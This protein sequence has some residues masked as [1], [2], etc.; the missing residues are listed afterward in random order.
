MISSLPVLSGLREI[1]QTYDAFLLD[2]WGVV[3]DGARI[4]DGAAECLER[5]HTA[6]KS[7]VFVS[8]SPRRATNIEEFFTR[9]GIRREWYKAIVTSGE[10]AHTLLRDKAWPELGR[11]FYNLW[12][13][14]AVPEGMPL[15]SP[16]CDGALDFTR[17]SDVHSADFLFGGLAFGESRSLVDFED[18][19]ALALS[20]SLPFLCVNPDRVVGVGADIFM[21][22]GRVAERYEEMG[23]RVIWIGKPYPEVY[24]A[25]FRFLEGADKSR[26]AAIGDS[27]VTDIAGAEGAGIAGIFN[28]TGIHWEELRMDHRPDAHDL[29]KVE[30]LLAAH[31]HRPTAALCG[32]RW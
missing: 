27:L 25:A 21:M 8:N 15:H 19:L 23:G 12:E 14:C 22:P 1:A 16:L 30:T 4:Y 5:L 26:V 13:G 9:C 31:P 18:V 3:W 32:L 7:L 2:I 24:D 29:E 28:M 10:T 11:K 20:R 6:G 17:V